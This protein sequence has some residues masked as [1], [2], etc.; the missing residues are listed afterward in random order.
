[1]SNGN[2][3]GTGTGTGKG[4]KPTGN[5][6]PKPNGNGNGNKL[7]TAAGT[8]T[9]RPR[10]GREPQVLVVHRPA[11]DDWTLPKGK[12]DPDEYLAAAAARETLEETGTQVR[13]GAPVHTMSYQVGGGTKTV[14]YWRGVVTGTR[15]RP[16]DK[17]VDKVVWLSPRNALAR[18]TYLDEQQLLLQGL[19][20]PDTTPFLIVRHAKAMERK[21]WTGRDQGRPITERGRRQSAALTPL[22]DA[23]GVGK[24][25]SSSSTR[26]VQT[27]QP[28]ARQTGFEIEK[29]STLSEEQGEEKPRAVRQLIRRLARDAVLTGMPTAVC[30]HRP[31]LPTMLESLGITA[32]AMQPATVAVAHLTADGETA[33]VEWHK[34]RF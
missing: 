14:H 24:L 25:A 12:L 28:Y 13:L 10:E 33:A 29:W 27:L 16:P 26:C 9:F 6:T 19:A 17:E 2:G 18:L 15:R 7:I 34:P 5:G 11:Y 4:D 20:V 21:N 31:V 22:L 1:M 3:N 30:G 23:Y 8:V 32:R